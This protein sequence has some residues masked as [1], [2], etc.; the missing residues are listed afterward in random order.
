LHRAL[1]EDRL[2]PIERE[3]GRLAKQNARRNGML[4]ALVALLAAFLVLQL[5]G[6]L[7]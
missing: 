2:A 5:S 7:F 1:A 3:L 6:L 4:A